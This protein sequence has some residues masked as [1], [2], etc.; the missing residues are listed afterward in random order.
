MLHIYMNMYLLIHATHHSNGQLMAFA[1]SCT[2]LSPYAGQLWGFSPVQNYHPKISMPSPVL[3]VP[4]VCWISPDFSVTTLI[5]QGSIVHIADIY[6]YKFYVNNFVATQINE[7][8]LTECP[9]LS[10]LPSPPIVR[11]LLDTCTLR[12]KWCLALIPYR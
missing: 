3:C 4:Y 5:T 12:Q 6:L 10:A 2:S 7:P 8:Y 9:G 1:P 11:G